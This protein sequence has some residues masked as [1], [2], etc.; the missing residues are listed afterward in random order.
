MFKGFV[1]HIF[2]QKNVFK[3]SKENSARFLFILRLAIT[4]A[5]TAAA[6]ANIPHHS[7]F[8]VSF[9][10]A[11]L[12]FGSFILLHREASYKR[13]GRDNHNLKWVLVCSQLR[14]AMND[15]WTRLKKKRVEKAASMWMW[16][17]C[18]CL[19]ASYCWGTLHRPNTQLNLYYCTVLFRVKNFMHVWL[20]QHELMKQKWKITMLARH[21]FT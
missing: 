9:Q 2:P 13:F 19:Y 1:W 3:N 21:H 16:M 11:F 6:T 20:V 10:H 5:T 8:V 7:T 14:D 17:C 15:I 18:D 4:K 12:S